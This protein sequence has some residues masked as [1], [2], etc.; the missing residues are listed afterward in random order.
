[1]REHGD[2]RTPGEAIAQTMARALWTVATGEVVIRKEAL[3]PLGT[4]DA[5]VRTL[6]SAISGGTE[7]LVL[8]GKVPTSEHDRMRAP[9]QVGDFPFPVKY[10]YAAV[11]IVEDGPSEWVGRRAFALHPH[12]DRFVVPV[13]ALTPVPDDIPPERAAL[14]ANLETA[15]NAVWDSGIGP[16][17]HIAI[18]GAGIVGSLI[19]AIVSRM[20]AVGLTLIDIDPA[21]AAR[22]ETFGARFKSASEISD[23]K[24]DFDC[25]FNTSGHGAGLVTA[26]AIAGFEAKIIELS[27]YGASEVTLPLGQAFHSRRLQ[28]IASQVG[29]IPPHRRARFDYARRMRVVGKLLNDVRLDTLIGERFAFEDAPA[30]FAEVIARR[31]GSA[32]IIRYSTKD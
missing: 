17:D 20:P 8:A 15:L 6:V 12:Q 24:D 13:T 10:G 23:L 19:A 11:G 5:R 22:A 31:N 3:P 29:Q 18:I 28:I 27:W 30:R 14:T 7:S 1:M 2:D 32:Q 25:V 21:K 16:G 9:W 26:L 4:G